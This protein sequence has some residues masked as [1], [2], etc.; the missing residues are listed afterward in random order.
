MIDD[1]GPID[2]AREDHVTFPSLLT[3]YFTIAKGPS[4]PLCLALCRNVQGYV[5]QSTVFISQQ[6]FRI[7][8]FCFFLVVPPS[9]WKVA[10]YSSI[11][12][13]S[14]CR[15]R[16]H[17]AEVNCGADVPSHWQVCASI[18][19]SKSQYRHP[20]GVNVCL[21]PSRDLRSGCDVAHS[22]GVA[23]V[24]KKGRSCGFQ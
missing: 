19:S 6:T 3:R 17:G 12:R 2:L 21:D 9:N 24:S 18:V 22:K 14:E 1:F 4:V 10:T 8:C 11:V 15:M 23:Q 13:R 5:L 16:P 20:K 7:V